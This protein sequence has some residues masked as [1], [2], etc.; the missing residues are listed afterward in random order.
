MNRTLCILAAL[1][2]ALGARFFYIQVIRTAHYKEK[3]EQYRLRTMKLPARRGTIYDRNGKELAVTVELFDVQAWPRKIKNKPA[4]AERLAPMLGCDKSEVLERISLDKRFV[5]LARRVT[6]DVGRQVKAAAIYGVESTPIMSRVYP[7]GE[8]ASHI[9][10]FTDID[11]I[12]REGL[13]KVFDKY[14]RGTDGYVTAEV[15]ARSKVI[16]GTRRGRVEPVHGMDVV[17]TID[18]TIQHSLEQ[19]LRKSYEKYSSAG[20]S[21]VVIDP[22]TGEIMALANMPTYDPNKVAQSDADS[23]R[24]RAVTDLYE[25]GSTL[26]TITACAGL[27]EKA[28]DY[29]D[30]F[31]CSGSMRIGNRTVRCSLHPPF[32]AGHGTVN[33]AKMLKYSC[34]MAAAGVAF[35]VGKEKLWEYEKKFG[36]YDK[37]GTGMLGEVAGWHDSWRNWED[38]R[39]ANIGFGQGIVVTPLQLANAYAVVANDGVMMRPYV[40]KEI[41]KTDGTSYRLYKPQVVRRVISAEVARAVGAMLQGCCDE[42]TGKPAVVD[43]YL[44]GGKTGSAQKAVAGSYN[45]GKFIA[46]FV[47][48]L[49]VSNPRAVI[50]VAVDEPKGIHWGATCAAPVFREVGRMAMWHM[51]VQPDDVAPDSQPAAKTARTTGSGRRER[52]RADSV[53]V[54]P[55]IGG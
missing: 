16:P 8:L 4:V 27:E 10:G 54:R 53:P 13:E 51:K 23:R 31:G 29:D 33:A 18:S 11:G 26:K 32:M 41:R 30:T 39:L 37:P 35:R 43:G 15:D 24:N 40:V 48:F 49:P 47:G 45:N 14:L 36:F 52:V 1:Y 22:R 17:L 46:S 12:G 28:I 42:G 7:G 19:E 20:A 25:P 2:L 44:T 5:F 34:N 38:V 21:A 6:T 55:H 50:L 3:A 9:V